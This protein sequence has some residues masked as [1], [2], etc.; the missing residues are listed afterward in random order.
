MGGAAKRANLALG[1][2]SKERVLL[3]FD[4]AELPHDDA[5]WQRLAACV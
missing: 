4:V 1:N 2:Y 3:V 5:A